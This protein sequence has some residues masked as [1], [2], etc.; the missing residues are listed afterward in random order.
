MYMYWHIMFIFQN[1]CHWFCLFF[2]VLGSYTNR[3][4]SY[5]RKGSKKRVK[6]RKRNKNKNKHRQPEYEAYS[7]GFS[8]EYDTP[9]DTEVSTKI[10]S[11]WQNC[12]H[13]R[14]IYPHTYELY[15]V[16]H[17]KVFTAFIHT[18]HLW[19]TIPFS[20]FPKSELIKEEGF[21]SI[22]SIFVGKNQ[23]KQAW[24]IFL[25]LINVC[26]WYLNMIYPVY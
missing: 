25:D 8:D 14:A 13:G 10:C 11:F 12:G 16:L 5:R 19:P 6:G 18:L 7:T 26:T 23:N 15:A 17:L 21:S 3:R 20:F 1:L 22:S 4:K 2:I 9:Y 24:Q